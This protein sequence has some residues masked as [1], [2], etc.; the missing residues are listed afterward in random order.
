[1]SIAD[2]IVLR[3]Y[4]P[5]AIAGLSRPLIFTNGVFDMLHPGHVE[6]L[7]SARALGGSLLVA[8]NSD[9]SARGLGK[10]ADRPIN[11]QA[12]RA[13]L[14]AALESVSLVTFFDERTPL[15]L[16]HEVRPDVYVKGGDYDMEALEET[17]FL[18]SYGGD[19]QAIPF[20]AGY[21]TTALLERIRTS[22]P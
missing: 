4:L 1:M 9:A 20:R 13:I 14:L 22:R 7:E 8:I 21:S 17:R 5:A 12:D 10:G 18:R 2:K 3:E 15:A 16:L 19:A 11:P 6:Y